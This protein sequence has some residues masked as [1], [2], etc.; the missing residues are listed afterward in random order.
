[1]IFRFFLVLSGFVAG[2]AIQRQKRPRQRSGKNPVQSAGSKTLAFALEN[3]RVLEA[4]AETLRENS[5]LTAAGYVRGYAAAV[6]AECLRWAPMRRRI[7][8]F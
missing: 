6:R 8:K 5:E 4:C 1:M 7:H 2:A 3:A